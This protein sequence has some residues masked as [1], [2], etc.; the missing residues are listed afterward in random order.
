MSTLTRRREGKIK[1]DFIYIRCEDKIKMVNDGIILWAF[2][3]MVTNLQI[4]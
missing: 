2:V 3:N 1:M 4:P